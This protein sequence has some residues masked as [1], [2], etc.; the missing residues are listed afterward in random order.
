MWGINVKLAGLTLQLFWIVVYFSPS[1]LTTES[2]TEF[3]INWCRCDWD[4]IKASWQIG[5]NP[6]LKKNNVTPVDI[7]IE[8]RVQCRM[9]YDLASF[10]QDADV[11]V[12]PQNPQRSLDQISW[13]KLLLEGNGMFV[14]F[15]THS[16]VLVWGPVP[17]NFMMNDR[18]TD[19][20]YIK[21]SSHNKAYPHILLQKLDCVLWSNRPVP[22]LRIFM[23]CRMS[24]T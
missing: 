14:L 23:M 20:S 11:K 1:F 12:E 4:V 3:S 13:I 17:I 10:Y 19:H 16:E 9:I 8:G 15:C 21:S 7:Q 24:Q 6:E 22:P 5:A 2:L 18:K